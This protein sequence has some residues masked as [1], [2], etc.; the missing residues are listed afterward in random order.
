MTEV[1]FACVD[2]LGLTSEPWASLQD[3]DELAKQ[4]YV[5]PKVTSMPSNL[6]MHIMDP[7]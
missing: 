4:L 6:P 2:I 3:Q 1:R 5:A 7:I